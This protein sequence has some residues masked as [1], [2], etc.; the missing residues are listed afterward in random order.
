MGKGKKL[1]GVR[2]QTEQD[3]YLHHNIQSVSGT[4][5]KGTRII[6]A[7]AKRLGHEA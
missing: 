6:L 2:F 5:T 7:G 4:S 3:F 1:S